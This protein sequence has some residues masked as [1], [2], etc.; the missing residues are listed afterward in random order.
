M[1]LAKAKVSIRLEGA[2]NTTVVIVELKANA[3]IKATWSGSLQRETTATFIGDT[4]SIGYEFVMSGIKVAATQIIKLEAVT[5]GASV[6]VNGELVVF[7]ETTGADPT[8]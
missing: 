7:E 4:G 6:E 1:Y 3:V 2:T 8:I 5:V